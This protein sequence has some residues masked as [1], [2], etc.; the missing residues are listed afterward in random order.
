MSNKIVVQ[1][2]IQG[3]KSLSVWQH[4]HINVPVSRLAPCTV[5]R[6]AMPQH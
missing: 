5:K 4:H 6:L 2:S 3:L 1:S